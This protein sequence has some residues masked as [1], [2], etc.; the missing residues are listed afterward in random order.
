MSMMKIATMIIT[1]MGTRMF[2]TRIM[3]RRRG[4][5]AYPWC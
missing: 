4:F 3:S 1:S 2:T 5:A